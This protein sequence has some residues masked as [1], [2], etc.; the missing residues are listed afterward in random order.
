MFLSKVATGLLAAVSAL[1]VQ[2]PLRPAEAPLHFPAPE[3]SLADVASDSF[4]VLSHAAFPGY[5]I[6]VKRTEGWCDP[7]VKGYTGYLDVDQGAKHMWFYFFESRRDPDNDD[8]V[9][10]V[11]GGP[12]CSSSMDML[13]QIGPCTVN[14]SGNGTV[15]NKYGWNTDVNIFFLDSPVNVGFSYAEFGEQVLTT[16]DASKNAAAFAF[17]FTEAFPQF[18]GRPFHLA[19]SSYGGR[20]V[21]VFAS[22]IYDM[23]KGAEA[24]GYTPIN[25]KSIVIGDG[26][27]DAKETLLAYYDMACTNASVTPVLDISTCVRMRR[28]VPRCREMLTA[29]CEL[30]LSDLACK[31]ATLFCEEELS[32]PYSDPSRNPYDLSDNCSGGIEILCY[33]IFGKIANYLNDDATRKLLGV[34]PQVGEF[35]GCN[36]TILNGFNERFD[37]FRP[38]QFYVSSLLE[39]GVDALIYVGTYDWI[40]NWVGNARFLEALEWHG[41]DLFNSRELAGWEVD[42]ET[43]GQWKEAKM[44]KQTGKLLF[45]TVDGA[46]HMV[47]YNKP[48]TAHKM[49]TTWI[50]ERGV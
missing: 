7:D 39:R 47:A 45:A 28:A 37:K 17:I 5:A 46:G 23:N 32:K 3:Q 38:T 41:Q 33:D 48:K 36:H 27:T 11:T 22:E 40:C 35:V 26:I 42:G 49:I 13:M 30:E 4:T 31:A 50:A 19:G 24:K 44:G 8:L 2:T 1:A 18:K 16:E 9:M 15:Y 21:P 20:Y 14:P 6:R 10:W 29:S 25:L 34:D 43:V 12:G